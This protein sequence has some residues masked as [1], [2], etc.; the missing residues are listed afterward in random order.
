[1]RPSLKG[2]TT[3]AGITCAVVGASPVAL[4]A[5]ATPGTTSA[6][7]SPLPGQSCSVNQGLF[8]GVPNLGPTGPLGPLGSHGPG[9]NNNNLPC[10]SSALN[11]GPSGPLGPGGLL[12]GSNSSPAQQTSPAQPASAAQATST[13][14][15][16]ATKHTSRRT[17]GHGKV[18]HTRTHGHGKRGAGKKIAKRH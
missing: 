6:S 16:T 4:A 14:H 3:I 17:R 9:A 11:L 2:L 18:R 12:G 10:G 13:T 8:P 5:A 1:M 7:P 15:Q